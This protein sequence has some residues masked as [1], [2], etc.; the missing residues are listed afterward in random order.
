MRKQYELACATGGRVKIDQYI[1]NC[2][3]TITDTETGLMWKRCSEGLSGV[4]CEEG[5]AKKYEWNDAMQRFK[6]VQYADY[7]DWRLPTIDELKTLVYCSNGVKDKDDGECN[8]GSKKPTI[9]QQAFPNTLSNWY[10]SGSPNAD[11]SDFA[12]L[13]S[14]FNGRSNYAYRGNDY[15]VRLV[16][17]GQ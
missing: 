17:G 16:R 11:F 13:V 1:D 15:A 7:S 5:E 2:N 9:N 12:W 4:N 6:K 3:G 8:D 14:F 10:W